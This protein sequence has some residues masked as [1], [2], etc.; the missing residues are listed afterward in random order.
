MMLLMA[1]SPLALAGGTL[2]VRFEETGGKPSAQTALTIIEC[3]PDLDDYCARLALAASA[4]VQDGSGVHSGDGHGDH[5]TTYRVQV[6]FPGSSLD[7]EWTWAGAL[8]STPEEFRHWKE[9]VE[10]RRAL[11]EYSAFAP[12]FGR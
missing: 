9:L 5:G 8:R 12:A 3:V 10:E 6:R 2:T 7:K 1:A 4:L 11:E